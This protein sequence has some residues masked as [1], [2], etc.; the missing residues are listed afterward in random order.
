MTGAAPRRPLA[1]AGLLGAL[2]LGRLPLLPLPEFAEA[3]YEEATVGLMARG[4]LRG[5]LVVFWWGQPY[6]GP[7]PA[8]LA[9]LLFALGPTTTAVLRLV[10]LGATLVA[11]AAGWAL[12]RR[13]VGPRWA[14]LTLGWWLVP[15]RS[16]PGTASPR[17]TTSSRRPGRP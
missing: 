7:V 10:P 15:R 12:A 11:A 9:A 13:L 16:S 2:A 3:S 6:L 4:I 5:D 1:A 14:L 8:Y 17:T